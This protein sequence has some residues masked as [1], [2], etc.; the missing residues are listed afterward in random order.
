MENCS[1]NI[2]KGPQDCHALSDAE[3]SLL[4]NNNRYCLLEAREADLQAKSEITWEIFALLQFCFFAHS[5][6]EL[7]QPELARKDASSLNGTSCAAA[8]DNRVSNAFSSLIQYFKGHL[9]ILEA[10]WREG[11]CESITSQQKV[12]YAG[13]SQITGSVL[14]PFSCRLLKKIMAKVLLVIGGQ[15]TYMRQMEI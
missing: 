4:L 6:L 13:F 14:I 15:C 12:I 9:F 7:R 5:P 11:G 1:C 2:L 10:A 8:G 3:H